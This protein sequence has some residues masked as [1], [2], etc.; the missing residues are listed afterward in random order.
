MLFDKIQKIFVYSLYIYEILFSKKLFQYFFNNF[1]FYKQFF[2]SI[3]KKKLKLLTTLLYL[4]CRI[5]IQK[6]LKLMNNRHLI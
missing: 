4:L 2:F 5:F 6:L 1:L 3:F